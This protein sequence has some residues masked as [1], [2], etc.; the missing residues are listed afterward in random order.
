MSRITTPTVTI[1]SGQSL[2]GPGYIGAGQL[3]AIQMPA[4]WDAADLT[5]QGSVDGTNFFNLFDGGGNEVDFQA[6]ASEQITVDKF[7]GA[8][9]IK[10]RSGT[11]GTPVNQTANRVITLQVSKDSI[12][13]I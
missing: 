11:S 2:S 4:A 13:R 10:V 8:I 12:G 9:W 6:A 7:R 5:F 3:V 1:L